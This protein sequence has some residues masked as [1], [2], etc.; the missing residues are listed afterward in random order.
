M[1]S[2][3][4]ISLAF[5]LS[6]DARE[7]RAE[8]IKIAI[9]DSGYDAA[10][11]EGP[12]LK[13][14]K[15]GH[16]D[17]ITHSDTIAAPSLHGTIVASVIATALKDVDYCAMIFNV[18][19]DNGKMDLL[20]LT[21]AFTKAHKAGAKAVNV[22]L[23]GPQHV[24]LEKAVIE[25]VTRKGMTMFVAAGNDSKDLDTACTS[26]PACYK[27]PNVKI[28]G[29]LSPDETQKAT[30]SNYGSVVN[31]WYPGSVRTKFG[32]AQGTSFAAPAA[33][34]DYVLSLVKQP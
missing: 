8:T 10:K 3:F 28:I 27:L 30:Y 17:V 26:Y 20:D 22:S 11:Q 13:L 2:L 9:I 33:L 7:A 24:Y 25:Y 5:L 1:K 16:W 31:A 32:Y 15:S 19:Q 34:A 6:V 14:C 23:V 18:E 21:D 29:A 4:L 12:P